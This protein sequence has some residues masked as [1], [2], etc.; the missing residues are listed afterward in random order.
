MFLIIGHVFLCVGY[1]LTQLFYVTEP[2][3]LLHCVIDGGYGAG[4]QW[5]WTEIVRSQSANETFSDETSS[6]DL[7]VNTSG[8]RRKA[9][10]WRT[11]VDAVT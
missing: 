11:P 1:V 9:N 2:N 10:R 8:Q 5:D 4:D 3:D 6:G 7:S